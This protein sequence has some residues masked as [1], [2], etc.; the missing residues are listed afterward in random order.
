MVASR[1]LGS[2]GQGGADLAHTVGEYNRPALE[3]E[4]SQASVASWVAGPTS[5]EAGALKTEPQGL[6]CAGEPLLGGGASEYLQG[7]SWIGKNLKPLSTGSAPTTGLGAQAMGLGTLPHS[8]AAGTATAG[9]DLL[10]D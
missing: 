7:H 5:L 3:V 6:P 4:S 10:N 8:G 9:L 2:L 1:R